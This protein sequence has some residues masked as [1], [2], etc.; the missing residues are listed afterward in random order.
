M[1]RKMLFFSFML[2][3][4]FALM[5]CFPG[6]GENP[7]E[8]TYIT[9]Q[10]QPTCTSEGYTKHTCTNCG[11]Y[12][13]D[14]IIPALPHSQY[15]IEG[16]DPT[17]TKSGLSEGIGCSVCGNIIKNQVVIDPT[18]HI[19]N[20]SGVETLPTCTNSHYITYKCEVCHVS[21]DKI[22]GAPLDHE[23]SGISCLVCKKTVNSLFENATRYLPMSISDIP[24]DLSETS[25]IID[26]TL[27]SETNLN[28]TISIS[29]SNIRII[30]RQDI[31]YFGLKLNVKNGTSAFLISLVDCNIVGGE[32]GFISQSKAVRDIIICTEGSKNSV[33]GAYNSPAIS[34][35]SSS[36]KIIGNAPL[37][38]I[39]GAGYSSGAPKSGSPAIEA[40]HLSIHTNKTTVM[41][42]GGNGSN[43]IT[44][45][46][47][48]NGADASSKG[49]NGSTG[50]T[51]GNGEDGGQGGIAIS[52][53]YG[54][55]IEINGES[56]V[57][58]YHGNGGTGGTGGT[59]GVGGAGGNGSVGLK[60][61]GDYINAGK[62]GTGGTG[63][64]GGAGGKGG[65]YSYLA[66]NMVVKTA[67]STYSE[68]NGT[69][70]NGGAG[71]AGGAGGKG[72]KGGT[73]N[74]YFVD[75]PAGNDGGEG[76]TG[77]VGGTGGNG[78]T[79]GNGGI[80]GAG[81]DGGAGGSNIP[82]GIVHQYKSKGDP[83]AQGASGENGQPG[84]TVTE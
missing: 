53:A 14:K 66:N 41:I 25:V 50:G 64:T 57:F 10:V 42:H 23:F 69:R 30:G 5:S 35:Y 21:F 40:K 44:G 82:F 81:G 71:G 45:I 20:D 47:G 72:G 33:E 19:E 17:C 75:K 29:S 61:K 11:D 37:V 62:G 31:S 48:V 56:V 59:G 77:G 32:G 28:T 1:I 26:L 55:Q 8:H 79:P 24:K 7:C 6:I 15:I 34:V 76:G 36:L 39:G 4:T 3:C 80:G 83:G 16:K 60:E 12:Y 70:G 65:T 84:E 9:F 38:L 27:L 67:T 46:T 2:F 63:G 52:L 74:T 43:G 78:S 51:G 22:L 18:G 13:T 73:T 54:G 68:F 49:K 58:V